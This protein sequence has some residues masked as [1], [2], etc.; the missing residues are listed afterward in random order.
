MASA[1]V[2]SFYLSVLLVSGTY[3][4]LHSLVLPNIISVPM[5]GESN[6]RVIR[7]NPECDNG[8]NG[9]FEVH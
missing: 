6:Q 8:S 3:D 1:A 9:Y 7:S 4:P 5:K 2:V